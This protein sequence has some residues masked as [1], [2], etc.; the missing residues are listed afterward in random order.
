MTNISTER[1]DDILIISIN[2]EEQLNSLN[3]DTFKEIKSLLDTIPLEGDDAIQAIIITGAGSKAF[4]AG[5]DIKEFTAITSREAEDLSI[6]GQKVFEEI[7]NFPVPVIAAINGYA[8]GG[9]FELA[10]CC[11]IRIASSTSR[12]GLPECK[13][14]LI[15][16]YGGTQRL[17]H[18]VGRAKAIEI[19][20]SGE[21][22]EARQAK[23]L[24]IVS[25]VT[26][27]GNAVTKSLEVI[28]KIT[29]HAPLSVKHVLKATHLNTIDPDKGYQ[30]ESK[31]FAQL[32]DTED[33]KE[34]ISAFLEKRKPNF[35]GN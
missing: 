33:S 8:L 2:R 14:G 20:C 24:G 30:Y 9:G 3:K 13:L 7:E 17:T 28:R 23:D 21:M 27:P 18:L 4:A 31:S 10:L 15:P 5:A 29:E 32:F 22:M 26:T 12:M 25:Y 16:G 11:H 34:G 35:Q 1:S 19:I 6:E